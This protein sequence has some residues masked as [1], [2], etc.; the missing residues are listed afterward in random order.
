MILFP[1]T[2]IYCTSPFTTVS[3]TPDFKTYKNHHTIFCL[4]ILKL[5]YFIH[6]L[7]Y[8]KH[9]AET[10]AMLTSLFTVLTTS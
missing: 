1:D 6:S 4:E 2:G 10:F 8:H 9:S 7:A 5:K 3:L